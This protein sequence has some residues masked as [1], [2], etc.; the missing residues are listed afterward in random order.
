MQ[1]TK[2]LTLSIASSTLLLF[3]ACGGGSSSDGGTTP[4]A[5]PADTTTN[6]VPQKINISIPDGLKST[7]TTTTTQ[8]VSFQKTT[9]TI[10]SRGYEQLKETIKEAERTIKNVKENMVY[11]N[12]MMPD[13][14]TACEGT[15]VNT[16]CTIPAGEISLTINSSIK[17]DLD[18]IQS[19]FDSLEEEGGLPPLNTE[20]TMG[21]VL[22]T[23]FDNTHTYQQNVVL[24]LKP[25]FSALGL[26]VNK[27]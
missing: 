19:E 8:K 3:A 15:A 24:D 17:S 4:P 9:E 14:Q 12:S 1:K 2:L 13:I 16:Q 20:L 26:T 23:V 7:R 18:D 21:Q 22:Y 11:L 27:Q 5:P 25:T 6:I 10:P